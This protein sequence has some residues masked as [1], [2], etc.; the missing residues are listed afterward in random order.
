MYRRNILYAAC[1]LFIC[2]AYSSKISAVRS[3][4]TPVK[5]Y[6]TWR[7]HIPED[8]NF[9]MPTVVLLKCKHKGYVWYLSLWCSDLEFNE[10]NVSVFVSC[11]ALTSMHQW[12]SGSLLTIFRTAWDMYWR[13]LK[14]KA[15][16]VRGSGD[17]QDCKTSRLPHFLD[18]QLTDGG[19]VVS[20]TRRP[21]FTPRKIPNT[22]FLL[23]TEL[24]PGP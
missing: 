7:R 21:P 16:P 19:E 10:K 14:S 11:N 15:N 2:L 23:E 22:H 3:S 20:L 5:L 17:P 18:N 4:E 13:Y 6:Q 24:T 12:N 1:R 9:H 8:R